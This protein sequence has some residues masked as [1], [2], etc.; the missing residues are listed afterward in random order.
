MIRGATMSEPGGDSNVQA[1]EMSAETMLEL[2]VNKEDDIK[3]RLKQ[4]QVDSERMV[5]E[6]KFDAASIKRTASSEPLGGELRT[7]AL[8]QAKVDAAQIEKDIAAK[9]DQLRATG[10]ERVDDA[11]KVVIDAVLPPNYQK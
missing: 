7:K 10:L 2:I 8:E 4:S 5:E 11:V 3:R 1:S 6:A 9:A